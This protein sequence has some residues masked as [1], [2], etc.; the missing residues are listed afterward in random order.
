LRADARLI[1]E[2]GLSQILEK[3]V[4]PLVN[5]ITIGEKL[6]VVRTGIF[7]S[8]RTEGTGHVL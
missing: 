3:T 1:N 5:S 4:V 2:L 7:L 6:K 8:L